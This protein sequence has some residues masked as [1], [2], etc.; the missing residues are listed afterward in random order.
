MDNKRTNIWKLVLV[1]AVA[2]ALLSLFS[3]S[4]LQVNISGDGVP[5][6]PQREPPLEY[7]WDQAAR[8]IATAAI[9]V[10]IAIYSWRKITINQ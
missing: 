5:N 8:I 1:I 9:S 2:V 3:L 6:R 10:L 7:P 4:G